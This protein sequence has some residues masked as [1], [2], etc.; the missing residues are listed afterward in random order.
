MNETRPGCYIRGIG[1]ISPQRTYDNE[2]FLPDSFT[3][4]DNCLTAVLP[5]FKDY[6]NP[7]QMRRLSRMLRMGLATAVMSLRDAGLTSP[8]AVI[9][10]TGYG[11]QDDTGKFLTE[12]LEQGEE[13]LTPTYFMQSTYNALSGL[14]ALV[15]KCRGY[16][17]T[18]AGRGFAFETA[19]NDAMML[20]SEK[21][22]GDVLVGSFDEVSPVQHA[23]YV[24]LG[25]FKREKVSNR[26]LLKSETTGTIQGE[27]TAFF[28]LSGMPSTRNL[29][30]LT[31]MRMLYKPVDETALIEAMKDFLRKNGLTPGD[32]DVFVNGI[33]GDAC[34]DTWNLALERAYFGHAVPVHFKHLTGEY[35]TASSFALWLSAMIFRHGFIPAAVREEGRGALSHR[36]ERVLI[37]NHFLARNYAFMLLDRH[38]C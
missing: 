30:R 26:Y 10:A 1:A 36:A 5:D 21:E 3:Y 12:I 24:R 35:A 28:L 34:R 17:T 7:F 16:N 27:G 4:G 32:I 19:L 38:V 18:Y 37:C 15:V 25:F 9:T 8:D 13:Q 22:A 2:V 23:E 29:C 14:I 6:I 33:S 11:F 31:A 20:L